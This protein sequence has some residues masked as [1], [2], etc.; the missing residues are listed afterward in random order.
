M[1]KPIDATYNTNDEW[2]PVEEGMYPAHIASLSTKEVNTRAGDAIIVNMT[3]KVADEVADMSQLLYKT[4][5]YKFLKDDNGDRIP[6]TNGKGQQKTTSCKHLVGRTFYDNGWFIFTQGSSSGK[7]RRYFELL[8][9][10]KIDCVEEEIDGDTHK[11]LVLIEEDDVIGKPVNI[12]VGRTSYVTR[13][14]KDLPPDQQ[15]R[16]TIFK[17]K[18]VESWTD[19]NTLSADELSSDVPF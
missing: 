18:T 17:V 14:T 15:E 9:T 5:G 7:N 2:I 8:D 1:A 10:L 19:G 13:D 4:E 16:K 12:T 3:Y 6:L 11:K